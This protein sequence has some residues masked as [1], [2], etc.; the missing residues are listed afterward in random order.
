MRQHVFL[1]VAAVLLIGAALFGAGCVQPPD[2]AAG[3]QNYQ[4]TLTEVSRITHSPS[5][6]AASLLPAPEQFA[7][8]A[9]SHLFSGTVDDR[10]IAGMI[11]DDNQSLFQTDLSSENTRRLLTGSFIGNES[12]I[13]DISYQK[14]DHTI[15]AIH[16]ATANAAVL[17][18]PDLT[19]TWNCTS[20]R[21][22]GISGEEPLQGTSLTILNQTGPL[23]SGVADIDIAGTIT[24]HT[25][26]G[27]I[28][29]APES[30]A[31]GII[32]MEDGEF[33]DME[34]TGGVLS[35]WTVGVSESASGAEIV[36]AIREYGR[37]SDP[38]TTPGLLGTWS[39]DAEQ[40]I[41][42]AG[43]RETSND[44]QTI[45]VNK[46]SGNL[47]AGPAFGGKVDQNGVIVFGTRLDD[48]VYLYRG[49]VE[50]DIIHAARLYTED[51]VKYAAAAVYLRTTA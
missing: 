24:P 48:D 36:S 26:V 11:F 10:Q 23:F 44:P 14:K 20:A 42:A 27:G 6:D 22:I 49:W 37:G 43:L 32:I 34:L 3:P 5:G 21:Q 51:G 12:R 30:T 50:K 15:S 13:V 19:G 17:Q 39:A 25:F 16:L 28:Y 18:Y 1:C 46:T 35:F 45:L 41:S 29:T 38:V 7:I 2:T 31:S 4:W 47:F 9:E 8:A 40:T 33:W